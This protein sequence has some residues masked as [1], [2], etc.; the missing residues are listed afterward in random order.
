MHIAVNDGTLTHSY[1]LV[2]YRERRNV[3][4][5]FELGCWMNTRKG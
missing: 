1:I 4:I 2:N 5:G 3:Y